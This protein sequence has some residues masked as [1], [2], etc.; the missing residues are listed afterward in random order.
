MFDAWAAYDAVADGVFVQWIDLDLVDRELLA[1]LL[2]TLLDAFSEVRIYRPFFRGTALFVASN[3]PL[4]IEA[5]APVAL[6]AAPQVA[7]AA[8]MTA[9]RVATL[10]GGEVRGGL[11][12]AGLVVAEAGHVGRHDLP[13]GQ[14]DDRAAG[15]G[16]V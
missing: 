2:A 11:V 4:A 9:G 3:A 8:P 12:P 14:R 16:A 10:L 7:S 6:A 1:S 15:A 13:A 5:H